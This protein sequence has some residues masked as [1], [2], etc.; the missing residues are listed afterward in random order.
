[1]RQ[2]KR[3]PELLTDIYPSRL[4]C[5][6]HFN[7]DSFMSCLWC[8][9]LLKGCLG[10]FSPALQ[11]IY[12]DPKYNYFWRILITYWVNQFTS[13]NLYSGEPTCVSRAVAFFI[14]YKLYVRDSTYL[15]VVLVH[16]VSQSFP[17]K[18]PLSQSTPKWFTDP[19]VNLSLTLIKK[20]HN[21]EIHNNR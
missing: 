11:L 20:I 21:K 19:T 15:F 6:L 18:G 1:M 8:L 12:T 13:V 4:Y 17:N 9:D 5:S 2:N 3:P 14:Y 7:W 16:L 10:P